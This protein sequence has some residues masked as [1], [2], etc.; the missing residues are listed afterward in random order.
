MRGLRDRGAAPAP[1]TPLVTAQI[2]LN[3]G[4]FVARGFGAHCMQE[5]V[6]MQVD[7]RRVAWRL[8]LWQV[9]A[10]SVVAVLFLV[11][12]GAA[13][14][15]SALLGGAIG[16]VATVAMV[17]VAMRP[18]EEDPRRIMRGFYRGEAVKLGLTVLLFA[19]ALKFF[20][21]AVGPFFAAYI[22][23]FLVYWVALAR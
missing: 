3:S 5:A 13:H 8:V 10:T 19:V 22:A 20:E 7:S 2:G 15:G 21:I 6:S 11:F 12:S 9:V 14:A 1:P 17:I 23:T 16:V 18:A 4:V